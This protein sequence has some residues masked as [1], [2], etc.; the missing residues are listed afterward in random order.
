MKKLYS[1][2]VFI[3]ATATGNAASAYVDKFEKSEAAQKT[4]LWCWAACVEMALKNGG[5]EV[6]QEVIVQTIKGAIVVQGASD[7]E[8]TSALNRVGFTAD[9]QVWTARA[10]THPGAPNPSLMVKEVVEDRPL[11]VSYPTGPLSSHVVVI[12]K[13]EYQ[14]SLVGPIIQNITIFDPYT[15]RDYVVDGRTVPFTTLRSWYIKVSKSEKSPVRSSKTSDSPSKTGRDSDTNSMEAILKK[16]FRERENKF[17]SLRS[18]TSTLTDDGDRTWKSSVMPPGAKDATIWYYKEDKR[19]AWRCRLIDTKDKDKAEESYD[20]AKT[21]IE[22]CFGETIDFKERES[23]SRVIT[24]R[25]SGGD[26]T[27]T[28]SEYPST[29]NCNVTLVIESAS[30]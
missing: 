1:L 28:F 20:D 23:G 2:L 21:L 13:V 11:I 15:G 4:P 14:P 6:S 10:I 9:G 27:L 29:K 30:R 12:H 24:K 22:K 17:L 7:V 5:V 16:V 25:Y 3:V 8:I 18:G 19:Y 26:V